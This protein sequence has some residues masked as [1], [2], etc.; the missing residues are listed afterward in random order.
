[1]IQCLAASKHACWTLRAD[2]LALWRN[3]PPQRAIFST[4][5]PVAG[6]LGPTALDAANLN[7]DVLAAPRLSFLRTDCDGRTLEATYL[8]AGNFYSDRSVPYARNGY[9]TSPPGIYGNEW[10]VQ[11]TQLNSANA[12]LLGQLQSLEFNARHCFWQG[13]CQFLVG[14]R[15]LQW[16]E[17]LRM[18]DSFS[19]P[20]PPAPIT[21]QGVDFYDTQCFNNLWGGQIGIDSVLLGSAG[22]ARIEGLVKA[23][24][25]Y[26][27][28]GQYSSYRYATSSGGAFSAAA[29]ADGPAACS[30]V[31]E[32]GLTAVMPV[33]SRWDV[34]CGY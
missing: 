1:M 6:G 27:H 34:R 13:S 8:Y 24:A 7:S 20:P 19:A 14:M 22:M 10:G 18:Q 3:A 11:G 30:F 21:D 33:S 2:T 9:V 29:R 17:T 23:G 16:N 28:A 31:G 26:N 15:W 4:I 25:Y 32:L 5:D 12:T